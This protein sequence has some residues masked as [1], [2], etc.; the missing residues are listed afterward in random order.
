[1]D[2]PEDGARTSIYLASSPEVENISGEFFN[3]KCKLEKPDDRFYTSVN[4]KI[5]WDYCQQ[6]TM[7]N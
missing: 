4:E 2:K 5:V 6:I 3:N 7:A 1:M